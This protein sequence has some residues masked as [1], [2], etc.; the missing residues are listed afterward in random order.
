MSKRTVPHLTYD[1]RCQIYALLKS[2]NSKR[3]VAKALH[4][5][6]STVIREVNR[7]TGGNGYRY[8]Q[9]QSF[10]EQRRSHA[11]KRPFK[12]TADVVKE[13]ISI[14]KDTQPSPVQI[15]GRLKDLGKVSL[16][17][18][19]IY[20]LIW[21]DKAEG[22]DLYTHLRHKAKKYNK[23]GSKKAGR[24]L[25]PGR[26]DIDERPKIVEEKLRFGDFELDTIVGAGHRGG[27]VSVVD[28]RTKLTWL[29]LVQR[30]TA[31]AVSKAICDA[32]IPFGKLHLIQ[33]MTADNGKEFSSHSRVSKELG[34]SFYFAKP[35]HA[36]ERGLNEHTNGLVRQYFPKGTDFR[37]VSKSEV[38]EVQR[39]LNNRPRKVLDF[40]T[41]IETLKALCPVVPPGAFHC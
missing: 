17:H 20:R 16:S 12:M 21:K 1:E 39:K 10:A 14:L 27:I 6:H 2:G 24:G 28:R 7:N 29:R 18:E 30:T 19:S 25:I 31:D 3:Q 5:S 22:G 26:V 15:A 41:P 4:R 32:L 37:K 9:A 35:Y 36:W 13:V 8:K 34:G 23:R 40:K 11:S 33:T 38:E